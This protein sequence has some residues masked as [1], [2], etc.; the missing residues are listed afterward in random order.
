MKCGII[1]VITVLSCLT[2]LAN[3]KESC[4]SFEAEKNAL[5]VFFRGFKE[6][7]NAQN[8]DRVKDMSGASARQWLRWMKGKER[9]DEFEIVECVAN[10]ATNVTA[11]VYVIGGDRGRYAFDAVFAMKKS[12]GE[13]SIETM[14]LPESDRLNQDFDKA[15][16]SGARLIKAINDC[17]LDAVKETVSFGGNRDFEVLLKSR[18]LSWIKESIDNSVKISSAN[19]IVSRVSKTIL[20]GQVWVPSA[21]GGTNVLRKVV[22]RDSKIDRAAPREETKEEFLRRFEKEKAEARLR[23]EKEDAERERR[24]REEAL[25]RRQEL[26]K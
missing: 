21:P 14:T 3:E 8:F 4:F 18:G 2:V 6:A 23:L 12:N 20:I 22:F 19:M 11:K 17:D 1:I 25:R 5:E 7:F 26:N 13:Y 10:S 9:L 16:K 15:A 24:Q